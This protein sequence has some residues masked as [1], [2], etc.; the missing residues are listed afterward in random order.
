MTTAR[1]RYEAKT[2]V[3]TFRVQQELYDELMKIKTETGLS[4]ADLV[5]LGAGITRDEIAG[6]IAETSNLQGK[7]EELKQA[8][9]TEKQMV[10][11]TAAKE[12]QEQLAKLE[13]EIQAFRLFDLGWSIEEAGFKLGMTQA[14]ISQHFKV[15]SEM[16]GE[17]EKVQVELLKKFLRSHITVLQ[18][19]ILWRATG[20][21]LQE[22][23]IQ[24]E[25]SRRMFNDPSRLTEEERDFL[26]TEYSYLV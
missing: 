16:R 23:K 10:A 15:W 21:A 7:L 22:S 12:R 2:R 20:S 24:L 25:H 6:K 5:K 8:V 1:E 3:V 18:E 14:E 9:Q 17:R 4:F 26:L 11:D 13:H 19:Q